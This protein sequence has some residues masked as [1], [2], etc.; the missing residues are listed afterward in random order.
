MGI[1]CLNECPE[2]NRHVRCGERACPFCG[3]KVA[4]FMRVLEYRIVSRLDR[5][6]AFGL[7]AALTAAGFLTNCEMGQAV[8]GAPCNPP[9]CD[10]NGGTAGQA[11]E[12][13][14]GATGGGGVPST[15]GAPPMAEGGVPGEGGSSAGG[16]PPVVSAGAGG[17]DALGGA[18]GEPTLGG[19][20]GAD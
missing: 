18:G 8:Y 3:A 14:V 12:P 20:G 6:R 11:G 19:A 13:G 15:A 17:E 2:C 5:S 9:G 4:S 7:G 16:A 1:D 10:P